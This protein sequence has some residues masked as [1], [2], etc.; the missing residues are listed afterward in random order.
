MPAQGLV[1]RSS[2]S[3]D[4][5]TATS[6]TSSSSL[7]RDHSLDA[8]VVGGGVVGL[9]CA[10]RAARRGLRVRVL[11]RELPGAGASRIAAGML[12]P[13]GEATWGEEELLRFALASSEA[14]P[15]FAEELAEASG[16]EVGYLPYGALHVALDRDDGEELGRRFA[17]M[18]EL[19]LD[20]EWLRPREG[21]RLEPGLSPQLTACVHAPH[22]AAADPRLLVAA[23]V[24]ALEREGA[25][26][27][28]GTNVSEP[29][30]EG[31]AVA[32]VRTADG[33]EHRAAW[34]VLA[35][36]AWSGAE[37]L[38]KALRPPVRPVKG[39]ILTLRGP[40]DEPICDRIVAT[41]RVY[42]V[43]REDGRLIVG[44]TVEECS[45][46][47]RVTA[48]AVHELLREAYRALPDVAELE[49]VEAL[50]GLRPGS[51]DN[52]PLIGA[53][54]VGGLLVASGHFR[55]GILLAPATAEAVSAILADEEPEPAV[56]A[57]DPLRFAA[58]PVGV[59]SSAEGATRG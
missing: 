32:G 57:F 41:E 29:I 47:L 7:S 51:P 55:N 25:E 43:P 58:Q 22:E 31:E 6:D 33:A 39:Q 27:H 20:A 52:A 9:A 59:G 44:A 36:G 42:M 23:L 53:G 35:A 37:W 34:T 16:I 40:A 10:W 14:W 28:S 15:R 54:G 5:L 2:R 38:P 3:G 19:G 56:D 1:V 17:L 4:E 49:L 24:A 11:E 30:F 8:I 12:A 45:F 50:A 13:V 48:G 26:V 46:D 18:R 21:R